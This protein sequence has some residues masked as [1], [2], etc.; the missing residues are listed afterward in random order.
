MTYHDEAL[1]V[2]RNPLMH[3]EPKELIRI[4]GGLYAESIGANPEVTAEQYFK[5]KLTVSLPHRFWQTP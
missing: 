1:D 3:T 4:I 5:G 2:L